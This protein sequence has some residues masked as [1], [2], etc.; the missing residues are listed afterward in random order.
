MKLTWKQFVVD[1]HKVAEKIKFDQFTPD[2]II[3][4]ARGGWVPAR[5]LSDDLSVKN[6]A[7]IGLKYKNAKRTELVAYSLPQIPDG[8]KDI[9]LVEDMLE[10]GK[11]LKWAYEHYKSEGYNVKTVSC[12]ITEFTS[13]LPNYYLGKNDIDTKFPWEE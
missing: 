6:I 4:I 5:L 13:F 10:S 12:Y 1:V 9:L 2:V 3:A 8:A 7:S 11:S